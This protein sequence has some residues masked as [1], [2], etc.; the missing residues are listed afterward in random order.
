MYPF[1]NVGKDSKTANASWKAAGADK[2]TE[3]VTYSVNKKG[4]V[5]VTSDGK[6]YGIKKGTVT[7]TAKT[8]M[9]KK[10]TLKVTVE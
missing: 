1:V 4:I 5:T 2:K 9:G 8:P 7:I 6:I 10:G 3:D